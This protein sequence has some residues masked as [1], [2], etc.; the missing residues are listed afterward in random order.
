LWELGGTK[1]HRR[2]KGS[3]MR[4]STVCV[5]MLVAHCVFPASTF[6]RVTVDDA[7]VVKGQQVMLR[8]ETKGKFFRKGGEL[9]EFFVGGTSLGRTLS[10]GDGVA[11]KP[12]VPVEA[13]PCQIEVNS[14]GDEDTGIL[15]SLREGSSIAF[16]DVESSLLEGRLS[17]KPKPG[18]QKAIE[19][20]N[21]R[22]PVVFLQTGFVGVK[23]MKTWLRENE[24][25]ESPVVPWNQGGIFDEITHKGLKVKAV[26]ASPDVIESAR[27]HRPLSFSFQQLDNAEWVKDWEEISKKLK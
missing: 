6:S 10:G 19:E 25:L 23:A 27:E 13:G 14:G 8:A 11:F 20:I 7:V 3:F 5:L 15:L 18:S 2:D 22:F 17:R 1:Y 9:V 16:V 21:Q 24:F 26:I 12:F 4:T